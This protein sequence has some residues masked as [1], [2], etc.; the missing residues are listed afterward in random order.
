MADILDIADTLGYGWS[1][2]VEFGGTAVELMCPMRAALVLL[3]GDWVL[4]GDDVRH[5]KEG[6]LE[7]HYQ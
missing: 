6:Q 7:A 4:I 1:A 5:V 3:P 2:V